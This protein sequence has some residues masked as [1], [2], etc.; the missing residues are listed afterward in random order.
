MKRLFLVLFLMFSLVDSVDSISL[1]GSGIETAAAICP[2]WGTYGTAD[3]NILFA[4]DGSHTS[5]QG[6][7]C[8]H[9]ESAVEGTNTGGGFTGSGAA[10]T[11]DY[12]EADDRLRWEITASEIDHDQAGGITIWIE[13]T[14]ADDGTPND[15]TLLEFYGDEDNYIAL[16]PQDDNSLTSWYKGNAIAQSSPDASTITRDGTTWNTIAGSWKVAEADIDHSADGDGVAWS[17]DDD[18]L[19]AWVV[20]EDYILLGNLDRA[21]T[22]EDISIRKFVVIA[23]Y[24]KAC[25]W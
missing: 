6:Y 23:G 2:D 19:I 16:V 1:I 9:D 20:P 14:I 7:A 5:G 12:D 3:G 15:C 13:Y 21:G 11:W 24:K 22:T 25:P 8:K 18:D 17:D 4:W 10:T